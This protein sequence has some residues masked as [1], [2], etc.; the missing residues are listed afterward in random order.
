MRL[1]LVA[2]Y[3][4]IRK[5]LLLAWDY[6]FNML[7]LLFLLG[8]VFLGISFF[9]GYGELDPAR[10]APALLGYLVWFYAV[11]IIFDMNTNLTQEAQ[12]G[13]LEQ[14][15]MSVA[16]AG[17]MLL[18]RSLAATVTASI[19][20][21]IAGAGLSL[22]L[23]IHIPLVWAGIPV[24]GI[25]VL[26][27]IG[28]GFILGGAMLVFKQADSLANLFQQLLLFLNGALLPVSLLP[29]WLAV[30]AKTLPTTQGIVVLRN[31]VFDGQ[32]LLAAWNDGSLVWLS[33]HSG[34][35]LVAGWFVFKLCERTAKRQGTLGQY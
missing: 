20:V 5:G 21:C 16:P 14:M 9:M 2:V 23:N 8:F 17:V 26:G 22:L 1:M 18:G 7:M 31:V 19:L 34:V 30:F 10:M 29:D 4:E 12:T 25:T 28:F 6:K 27:L 24:L 35:Y 32:S 3:S 33:I 15:Y 13:T 11:V